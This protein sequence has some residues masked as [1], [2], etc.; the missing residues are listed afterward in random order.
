MTP[1]SRARLG[2]D[3]S[4]GFDLAREMAAEARSVRERIEAT[5]HK[6]TGPDHEREDE[7]GPE[8]GRSRR[9]QE[10]RDERDDGNAPGVQAQEGLR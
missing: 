7:D 6:Q 9:D 4:R 3:L 2:L 10:H 1:R 8:Q 5:F